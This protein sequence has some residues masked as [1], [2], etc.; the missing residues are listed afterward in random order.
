MNNKIA[1][2]FEEVSILL[3]ISGENKFKCIAYSNAAK[4]I[5]VLSESV[6]ALLNKGELQNIKGIGKGILQ[7]ISEIIENGELFFH[8]ELKQKF[9]NSIL[10]LLKIQGVGPKKIKTLY[11]KLNIASIDDLKIACEK[12]L[13]ANLDGFREKTQQNFL[14]AISSLSKNID[15]HLYC[16]AL[17]SAEIILSF[18][19]IQNE[20]EQVEIAGSIR[21]KK[22]II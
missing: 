1:D 7:N 2:I 15:K 10:E 19:K 20:V 9:P 13:I 5:R 3:E 16:D 22:E 14:S 4:T 21:R 11:D 12:N 6:E 8:K 17:N 18:L